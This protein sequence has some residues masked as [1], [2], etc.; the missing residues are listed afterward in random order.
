[1]ALAVANKI[2]YCEGSC[3][4]S[5]A[6]SWFKD[7]WKCMLL[8]AVQSFV[9]QTIGTSRLLKIKIIF[10]SVCTFCET[11]NLKENWFFHS[12][13]YDI[14]IRNSFLKCFNV[15][16]L[17]HCLQYWNTHQCMRLAACWRSTH[18]SRAKFSFAVSAFLFCKIFLL[19]YD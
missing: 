6:M 1:M 17:N 12:P 7:L 19:A 13:P 2:F 14:I 9:W 10:E 5:M 8:I 4:N 3:D 18:I 15:E 16:H 11:E